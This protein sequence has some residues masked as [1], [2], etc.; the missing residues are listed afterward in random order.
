MEQQLYELPEGWEWRPLGEIASLINGR[1][2]KKK[3]LL[4]KGPMPVLRVGNFFSNRSWYYSNLELPPEKYCDEGDLLYAWSASFGPRIWEGPRAIFHY[5][6]WKIV[7]SALL[8]KHYLYWL[9]EF[10][11]ADIKAQGN[12]VGMMHATKG[13]MEKRQ[14]PLPPLKEQKR[15][16]AKLDALFTRIDTAITHLQQ[17]FELSKALFS[18]ALDDAF[19]IESHSSASID[20]IALLVSGQ[21]LNKDE[22]TEAEIPESIP[23]LTGPSEFGDISP[24]PSRW[25]KTRR[26]VAVSGDTLI[27]VKGSGVGKVNLMLVPEIAISRQLMAVRSKGHL[28]KR[29]LHLFFRARQQVFADKKTGAAI[30]GIGRRDV[31]E[32]VIPT[33]AIDE[34]HRIVSFLD[35]LSEHT[36]ALEA[37]TQEKL[38]DLNTLK[39]SLLDAAFKGQL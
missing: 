21:H 23:Y 5:H 13:G 10:D 18:S 8:N 3:E 39:A 25:T 12:G 17:T 30:P 19:D 24:E 31:L 28:D 7:T 9:L 29:Y 11:S 14:I 38:N 2:Y 32:Q 6:I 37:T 26:S 16:V 35:A 36:S 15:I 33:P 27:T 20:D 1:A 22:Y 4:E 34:Q